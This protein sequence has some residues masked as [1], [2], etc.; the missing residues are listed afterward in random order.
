MNAEIIEIVGLAVWLS[1][2]IVYY[3]AMPIVSGLRRLL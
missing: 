1:P 2:V 3:V